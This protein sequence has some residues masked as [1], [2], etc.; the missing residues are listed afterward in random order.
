[1]TILRELNKLLMSLLP[2]SLR[3]LVLIGFGE[4]ILEQVRELAANKKALAP[5]LEGVNLSYDNTRPNFEDLEMERQATEY[6]SYGRE[7]IER[8]KDDWKAAGVQLDRKSVV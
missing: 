5:H 2:K 3:K 6:G 7:Y 8:L 4:E 1:M